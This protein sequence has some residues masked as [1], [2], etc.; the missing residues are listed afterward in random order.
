MY[1][2]RYEVELAV[3]LL[4]YEVELAVYL[5]RYEVELAVYLRIYEVEL[6]VYVV[7]ETRHHLHHHKFVDILLVLSEKYSLSYCLADTTVLVYCLLYRITTNIYVNTSFK[8]T[9]T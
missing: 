6:A 7:L 5:R 8:K 3:Y 9:S 2:R 4:L 1:L